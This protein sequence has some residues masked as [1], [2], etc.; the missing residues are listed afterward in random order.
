MKRLLQTTDHLRKIGLVTWIQQS[1]CATTPETRDW[2]L[3]MRATGFTT[4]ASL[5][6]SIE[7]S[8]NPSTDQPINQWTNATYQSIDH[9]LHQSVIGPIGHSILGQRDCESERKCYALLKQKNT[10]TGQTNTRNMVE[11][12]MIRRRFWI[13][14]WAK[15]KRHKC[16]WR[17]PRTSSS[18]RNDDHL[19]TW[20]TTN[21]K[22]VS[23]KLGIA[24]RSLRTTKEDNYMQIFLNQ[25]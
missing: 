10:R 22:E 14:T 16:M 13:W 5:S 2:T 18:K 12:P 9:P 24:R 25:K 1:K 11:P 19:K 3:L 6:Q 20:T 21:Q 17:R 23:R 4:P 7:H 8:I 15:G